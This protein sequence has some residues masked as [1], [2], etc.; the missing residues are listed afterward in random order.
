MMVPLF[1]S[2]QFDTITVEKAYKKL[3]F[4]MMSFYDDYSVL[5]EIGCCLGMI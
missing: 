4:D 1:K 5:K 2:T 3:M